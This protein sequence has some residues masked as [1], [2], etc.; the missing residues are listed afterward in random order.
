MF[1][2]L[3]VYIFGILKIFLGSDSLLGD[4]DD[5]HKKNLIFGENELI[6][7]AQSIYQ[8]NY[9]PFKSTVIFNVF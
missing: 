9:R 7:S 1:N 2:M 5:E 4:D 6:S 3:D 8:L